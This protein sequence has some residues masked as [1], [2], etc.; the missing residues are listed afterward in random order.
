MGGGVD[1]GWRQC[2][3]SVGHQD[4]G[5]TAHWNH[6]PWWGCFELSQPEITGAVGM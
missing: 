4:A 5:T 3:L 1:S 6:G 2:E